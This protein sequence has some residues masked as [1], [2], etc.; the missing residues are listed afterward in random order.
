V[1]VQSAEHGNT[2]GPNRFSI[3]S[4]LPISSSK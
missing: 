4:N 2:F 3:G 1:T